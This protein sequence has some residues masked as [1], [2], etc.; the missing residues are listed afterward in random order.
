MKIEVSVKTK[1]ASY[2]RADEQLRVVM[3]RL[4]DMII[5]VTGED[6]FFIK[7]HLVND[8]SENQHV[9]SLVMN[10]DGLIQDWSNDNG[11]ESP[12]QG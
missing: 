1:V 12:S 6:P 3:S 9:S 11:S 4:Y 7:G 10:S 5:E 8:T 2:E